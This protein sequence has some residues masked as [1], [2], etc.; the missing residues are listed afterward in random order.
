MGGKGLMADFSGAEEAET[1]EGA[2]ETMDA[3]VVG[4]VEETVE[5]ATDDP[6]EMAETVDDPAEMAGFG[7]AEE[8][9]TEAVEG[10][11]ETAEAA[12][13]G[14]AKGAAK[15]A[16]NTVKPPGPCF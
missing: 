12:D 3:A 15:S 14:S 2:V 6:A 9:E 7:A 16:V 11:V 5:G 4:A 8:T 1:V 13:V 10:A